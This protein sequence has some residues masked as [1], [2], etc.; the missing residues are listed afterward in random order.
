LPHIGSAT[1]ATR[2][3]MAVLA[4]RNIREYLLSG[5]PV[6]PVNPQVLKN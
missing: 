1:I 5:K 3:E 4:A 6:T 2:T